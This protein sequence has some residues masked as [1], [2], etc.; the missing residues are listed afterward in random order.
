[1]C[2]NWQKYPIWTKYKPECTNT[3]T[4]TVNRTL[5]EESRISLSL[6]PHRCL[7]QWGKTRTQPC[8]S[9]TPFGCRAC[10]VQD[11]L[12]PSTQTENPRH[13]APDFTLIGN[14]FESGTAIPKSFIRSSPTS[15]NLSSLKWQ[16]GPI[17]ETSSSDS[18]VSHCKCKEWIKLSKLLCLFFKCYIIYFSVIIS[19]C[20]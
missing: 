11:H 3:N 10:F 9:S 13:F 6:F 2:F 12:A 14:A 19:F 4:S 17:T 20:F 5:D 16:C 7:I 15:K 18:Q 1:M 8:V